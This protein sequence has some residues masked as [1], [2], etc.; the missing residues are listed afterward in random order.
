MQKIKD[1]KW[2]SKS[3]KNVA[4][5]PTMCVGTVLAEFRFVKLQAQ[6]NFKKI[7]WFTS[8]LSQLS[9]APFS[10]TDEYIWPTICKPIK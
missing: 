5:A 8:T 10:D 2:C 6:L 3:S 4:W 1:D 9:N 7:R